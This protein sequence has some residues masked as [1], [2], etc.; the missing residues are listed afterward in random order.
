MAA[1]VGLGL[2]WIGLAGIAT[3]ALMRLAIFF[4]PQVLFDV[5]PALHPEPLGLGPAGSMVLD[6][7][8]L[9]AC[10]CGLAGEVMA[11][12]RMDWLLLAAAGLPLPL[13]IYHGVGDAGNLWR[14]STW[15]AA[16]LASAVTAHL[17][18]DPALRRVMIALLVAAVV[19]LLARGLLQVPFTIPGVPLV[20]WEHA[21]TVATFEAG[22]DKIF[23][24]RGWEPGSASARIFERRLRHANVR[25]WFLTTNIFGSLLAFVVVFGAGLAVASIRAK[26]TSGWPALVILGGLVCALGLVICGSKGAILAAIG[27]LALLGV[28]LLWRPARM[29]FERRGGP[30]AIA[31]VLAAIVG[32]WVRGVVLPEGFAGERSLLFRWHY[33]VAS[34]R[35]MADRPLVGVGPDGFQA[36]YMKVR[37]PRNPEEVASAHSIFADWLCTLGVAGVGWITLVVVL[38]W[39]AGRAVR[40]PPA[41]DENTSEP[42]PRIT[43]ALAAG[44]AGGLGLAAALMI[45]I[46]TLNGLGLL[47]R[48]VGLGGFVIATVVLAYV[49][50][51]VER[52][53]VAAALT[54]AVVALLV[55]GQ[56]EMTFYQPGAVVWALCA[57][58]AAGGARA[59]ED[60]GEH[61]AAPWPGAVAAALIVGFALV[62]GWVGVLPGQAQARLVREA[63]SSV[64]PLAPDREG[65][66]AQRARAVELLT[67]AYET[68]PANGLPLDAA[69]RQAMQAAVVAPGVTRTQWLERVAELAD[70]A[71]AERGSNRSRALSITARRELALRSGDERTWARLIADAAA[72]TEADPHG[73]RPWR[74]LGDLLWER[75]RAAEAVAA[76]ERALQADANFE[77]DQLKRL[78]ERDRDQI[79]RRIDETRETTQ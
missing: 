20:G 29:L 55:H 64:H 58:G 1:R 4:V 45:E 21:D 78:P 71:V 77:L 43:A 26:L 50:G 7:L 11:G 3:F 39:R 12:R 48:V 49:V 35:I 59:A 23:R 24:D 16:A 44:A 5:D 72:L 68:W 19:P 41:G 8:L 63:A 10:A 22:G 57:V 31:C 65:Q 34:G 73:I 42:T 6:V 51:A 13:V 53:L 70:R 67:E 40:A 18:R 76:Y 74:R 37:V 46:E 14:G 52:R 2:R 36:Q 66:L 27:G 15:A 54:A 79:R 32:V 62:V 61:G 9:L 60:R 75:G 28:G 47:A 30:I 38:L 17:V 25:G 56:I 33:L 69:A